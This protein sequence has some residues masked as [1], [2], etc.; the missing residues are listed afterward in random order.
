MWK[1]RLFMRATKVFK[2]WSTIYSV[3]KGRY[4]GEHALL[5]TKKRVKMK[6]RSGSTDVHVVTEIFLMNEYALDSVPDDSIILDIGAHIG[7]F[8]IYA[9]AQN[10]K[11]KVFCFEPMKENFDLLKDNIE[12]NGY[13]DSVVC[14]NAGLAGG[15]GKRSIFVHNDMAAHSMVKKSSRSTMIDTITM[16]DVFDVYGITQ[17]GYLKMDCEGAEYEILAALPDEYL[18]RISSIKIEYEIVDSDDPLRSLE[19][20]L[21]ALGFNVETVKKSHKQGFLTAK[22]S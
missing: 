13:N 18:D 22:R 5:E 3:Y 4:V 9:C 8:A 11:F 16:K 12:I 14:I 17:C 10:K 1:T 15:S 21:K 19:K 2:N 6:I 7:L 20:R